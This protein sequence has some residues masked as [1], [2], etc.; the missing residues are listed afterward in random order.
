MT[1]H[2]T[3]I[4][5]VDHQDDVRDGL[6]MILESEGWTVET[7]R[8][9]R[10][11]LNKLVGGFSPCIILLDLMSPLMN[12]ME[13]QRE[14]NHHTAL[15]RIPLVAY[16]GLTNVRDKAQRFAADG[17]TSLPAEIDRVLAAVRQNCAVS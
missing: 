1:R 2:A 3:P 6:Q 8:D 15:Q 10:D 12:A 13:F 7:L 14:L 17:S 4:L 11:A 9:P 5:V 16:A